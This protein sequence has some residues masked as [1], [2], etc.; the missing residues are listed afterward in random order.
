MNI[1]PSFPEARLIH[2]HKPLLVST[3]AGSTPNFKR[4]P[5]S[6]SVTAT[7]TSP[8]SP[9]LST[10]L[11]SIPSTPNACPLCNPAP[12]PTAIPTVPTLTKSATIVSKGPSA[13]PLTLTSTIFA[14]LTTT[15]THQ[16]R[17][18][19]TFNPLRSSRPSVPNPRTKSVPTRRTRSSLRQG[20][21]RDPSS[22]SSAT[23]SDLACRRSS[24]PAM[25]IGSAIG[26]VTRLLRRRCHI[27]GRMRLRVRL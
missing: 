13:S 19:L 22:L 15:Q 17:T 6:T 27:A 16:E 8:L 12:P 2:C 10:P 3:M 24:G 23:L 1:Q 18:L 25:R 7:L 11:T 14:P 20:T 26:S 4:K 9:S 21:T 5:T